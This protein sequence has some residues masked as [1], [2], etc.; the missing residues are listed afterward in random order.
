MRYAALLLWLALP[1]GLWLTVVVWGTPHIALTYRFLDNGEP[2]NPR[3][4][5]YYVDCTYY[6][7][8]GAI[9]VNAANGACPWIR[10]L[11]SGPS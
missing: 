9:T 5:R 4:A 1:I 8:A 2:H 10:F 3:A 7:V 6:G 11:P